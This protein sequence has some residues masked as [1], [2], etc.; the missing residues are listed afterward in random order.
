M[1][2]STKEMWGRVPVSTFPYLADGKTKIQLCKRFTGEASALHIKI[3]SKA[4]E[5]LKIEGKMLVTHQQDTSSG[6][7]KT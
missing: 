2:R 5:D 4:T 7:F 3:I 6:A 1:F